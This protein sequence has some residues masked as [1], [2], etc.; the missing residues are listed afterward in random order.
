MIN[1]SQFLIENLGNLEGIPSYVIKELLGDSTSGQQFGPNSRII[2]LPTSDDAITLN[3]EIN[4]KI[5]DVYKDSDE[6]HTDYIYGKRKTI[7]YLLIKPYY[8]PT[9]WSIWKMWLKGV[10][11]SIKEIRAMGMDKGSPA[12]R[13]IQ[14]KDVVKLILPDKNRIN[15]RS[16]RHIA[17]AS[18]DPLQYNNTVMPAYGIMPELKKTI[19]KGNAELYLYA[20]M[21]RIKE[22]WDSLVP[23]YADHCVHNRIP[24]EISIRSVYGDKFTT[25]SL[26]DRRMRKL[27]TMELSQRILVPTR[28]NIVPHEAPTRMYKE[29]FEEWIAILKRVEKQLDEVERAEF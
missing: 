7:E 3:R 19:D 12:A 27:R 11:Y 29:A 5:A 8:A 16:A 13:Y 2:K 23:E 20:I 4:A 10:P 26:T 25:E 1:F 24:L 6:L 9:K 17:K 22:K 28:S 18:T 14:A 21:K 15:L